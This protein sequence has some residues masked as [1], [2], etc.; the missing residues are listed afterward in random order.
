MAT[1]LLVFVHV[2][3]TVNASLVRASLIT[4]TGTSTGTRANVNAALITV[5]L[6]VCWL[7]E[8]VS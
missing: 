3:V 7:H 8:G 4:R 1:E 2:Q 5:N 6:S